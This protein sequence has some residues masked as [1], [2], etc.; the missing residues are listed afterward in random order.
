M[1]KESTPAGLTGL[2]GLLI[3]AAAGLVPAASPGTASA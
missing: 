1:S 2:N 3:G